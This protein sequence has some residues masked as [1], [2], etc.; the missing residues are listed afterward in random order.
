M[1]HVISWISDFKYIYSSGKITQLQGVFYFEGN[2]YVLLSNV[3]KIK[4]FKL[5]YKENDNSI[6]VNILN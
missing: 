3:I 5:F 2:L 6:I 4:I 1:S